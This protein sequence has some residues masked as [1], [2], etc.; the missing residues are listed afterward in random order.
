M[1]V[2]TLAVQSQLVVP[3]QKPRWCQMFQVT[4]ALVHIKNPATGFTLEVVVVC[5]AR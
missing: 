4:G 2:G 1:A 3:H 5:V